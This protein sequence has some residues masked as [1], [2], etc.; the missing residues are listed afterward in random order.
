[1][2]QTLRTFIALDMPAEIK[3]AL[4]NYMQPLK[5]LRGRVSWTKPENLHLTLKFLGD[6]PAARLEAIAA[7][8]H[9]IAA[10]TPAFSANVTGTGVFPNDEKPRVLWVGLDEPT[11][12]LFKLAQAIDARMHRYGFEKEKRAFT[13]HL[14]IG[15]VKEA[16]IAEIIRS[17]QEKPLAARPAHFNEII[18]MQSELHTAGSIYTPLR[19]LALSKI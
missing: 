3:T 10:V 4:A 14:T 18:F 15:R 1:M 6:T 12:T 13:P 5:S 7:V 17:L 19:K 8:L 2:M 9:E 16:R 11:G